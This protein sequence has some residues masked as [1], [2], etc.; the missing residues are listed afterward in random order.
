LTDGFDAVARGFS[1]RTDVREGILTIHIA[2]E[3]DLAVTTEEGEE[4]ARAVNGEERV[5]VLDL[6]AVTFMDSSGLR[7]LVEMRNTVQERG[8][9]LLLG[10]LSAPVK[11]VVEVA[12]LGGWFEYVDGAAF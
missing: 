5:V 12:G 7:F 11:R 2:G 10:N 1:W 8:A 3:L 4:L 9:R 6:H